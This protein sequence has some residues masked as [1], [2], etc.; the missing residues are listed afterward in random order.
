MSVQNW[1][2]RI[3]LRIHSCSRMKENRR[4][5]EVPEEG[6]PVVACPDNPAKITSKE[7]APIHSVKSGILQ[8][9]CATGPRVGVGLVK[10]AYAHRQVDEQPSKRSKNN[11][12]TSAVAMLKKHEPFDRTGRPVFLRLIETRSAAEFFIDFTE[13]LRHTGTDPMCNIHENRCTSR[14]HSRPK[15]FARNDFP[16]WT[17]AA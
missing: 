10:S 13:E 14:T 7:V 16:K 9:T 11:G 15:F 4:E 6:V 2:S 12:D 1:H 17:S 8:N 5:P 3:R